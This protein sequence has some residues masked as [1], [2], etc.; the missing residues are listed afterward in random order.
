MRRRKLMMFITAA[1]SVFAL[2]LITGCGRT[3]KLPKPK[4]PDIGKHSMIVGKD[5]KDEDINEFYY[6]IENINYDAYF[7]RYKFYLEDGRHMF[8]FEERKRPDDY[9]PTTEEDTTAKIEYEL[10]D[11]EWSVFYEIISGGKVSERKDDP[12]SGGTGPWTYLYWSG[13]KD[14]YQEYSFES[15]KN[16]AAFEKL[17]KQLVEKS[18]GN[19][20]NK[21]DG[22]W[23]AQDDSGTAYILTGKSNS[24]G[25][26]E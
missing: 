5:I 10:S 2:G 25:E 6:T 17:C 21:Y 1:V 9:G 3:P 22:V 12:D 15:Q 11:K 26:E 16:R 14:K 20:D 4:M 23:Y 18:T 24:K 19:T 13:D 8:F 7:L